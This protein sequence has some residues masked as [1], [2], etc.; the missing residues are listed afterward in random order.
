MKQFL[1]YQI[2]GSVFILWVAIFFFSSGGF[3]LISSMKIH[4]SEIT[5]EISAKFNKDEIKDPGGKKISFYH[6]PILNS[7]KKG[8]EIEV[9]GDIEG[10]SSKFLV[11]SID[12]VDFPS[13]ATIFL[14]VF[15]FIAMP[16][17]VLIHQFSVLIKNLLGKS[18]LFCKVLYDFPRN[19][20]VLKLDFQCKK[21]NV[22]YIF[23]RISS[24]NSFYYV[25]VDNG[26]WAPLFAWLV[27]SYYGMD[28]VMDVWGVAVVIGFVTLLYV[29]QIISEMKEYES[30]LI[31]IRDEM[32]G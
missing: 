29:Y 8:T 25:R 18:F 3:D 27:V 32:H 15:I 9:V 4:S 19:K 10:M 26:L 17:G 28:I 23:D 11:K 16:V 12:G 7:T 5:K 30:I 22:E 2:S 1:R 13:L 31:E 6:E 24:L 14:S 21:S 20:E